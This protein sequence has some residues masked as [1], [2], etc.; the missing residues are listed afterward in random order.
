MIINIKTAVSEN[1][2]IK[3]TMK[4]YILSILLLTG[5]FA[6]IHSQNSNKAVSYQTAPSFGSY[7]NCEGFVLKPGFTYKA[8]TGKA[9]SFKADL[10]VCVA[11]SQDVK[12]S[13]GQNY[14][15][16][17]TPLD[18]TAEAGFSDGKL[19][20]DYGVRANVTV[21]YFDGLGRPVQ[22][23]QRKASADGVSDLVTIQEYDPFGRESNLWL[24]GQTKGNGAYAD[25]STVKSSARTINAEDQNPYSYPVYEASPL[26]RILEQY[27]PGAAWHTGKK[28]IA[29]NY[30][31]NVASNDAKLT[32]SLYSVTG[33]GD[34]TQ[35]KKAGNYAAGELYVTEIKDE[36]QN[37][38][39]EFKDKLGQVI[40]TRQMDGTTAHDTYYVYDDFGNLCYVLPPLATDGLTANSTWAD[41]HASLKQ[42]AYL[43][44]YNDR[45][46]CTKKQLPGCEPIN[47]VYDK[48][49]RLIFSQDGEQRKRITNNQAEWTFNKYD[50]FS[51]LI[52]SGIYRTASTHK[53]MIDVYSAMIFNESTGAGNYGYTWNI[54]SSVPVDDV[55]LINYYDNYDTMLNIN[56]YYKTNLA[57][58]EK[59]GY[60]AKYPNA[61][62]LLVGTRIK[63]INPDG[64]SK[65]TLEGQTVTAMYYD[66]RGNLIQSHSTNHLGG[67]ES[68]YLAY[69]FSGQPKKKQHIHTVT[70]D[71][72]TIQQQ[73]DY[74]YSYDHAGRL[75]KMTHK[76]NNGSEVI[77]AENTYDELG[78]LKTTKANNQA[79]LN[80]TYTYTVRSWTKI[81]NNNNDFI[82]TLD[83]MHNGNIKTQQWK[84]N[85]KERKYTFGYDQLSRLKSATYTSLP[86]P[87]NSKY[88][89]SYT[90]DKHGNV[91][92][93]TRQGL[94][95]PGNYA[96]IDKVT[97]NYT[98][99][100]L[101]KATD[102]IGN[103]SM[104][105]SH[106]FKNYSNA[107]VQYTYN[108]NG[109]MT[110]DLNK[111]I[112]GIKYNSLNLPQE[113]VI[114]HASARA[115][116]YYSYNAAGVK[117][118]TVQK[119]DTELQF[120]PV[121]GTTINN[122]GLKHSITKDYVGNK[123]YENGVL[124]K[125][126][127]DNGYIENGNYYFYVKDH[128][129]NNR[130][131][132]NAAA[133][134]QQTNQYYPFGMMF[135]ESSNKVQDYKYNGKE[136]DLMHGLNHYDYSA[137]QYDPARLQFTTVDP[138]AENYYSW[139]PYA[140]VANN[141]MRYIDPTGMDIIILNSPQ[142][143]HGQGHTAVLIGNEQKGWVY[144]SK[145]G[146]QDK[147]Y[148]NYF[149]GGP[150][151]VGEGFFKSID[152]FNKSDFAKEYEGFTDRARFTSS[153][154]QDHSA[155]KAM[156]SSANSWYHVG[157]NNCVDAV[158][159][160]MEAIGLNPGY[161]VYGAD[162]PYADPISS[163]SDPRP[164]NRF[165]QI[166]RANKDRMIPVEGSK[167]KED[168][169]S[170]Q[171]TFNLASFIEGA[172]AAGAKVTIK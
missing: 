14:I 111:G 13:T 10:S 127:V 6:S 23:V 76:L 93:T 44:K 165:Q 152:D 21:R 164:T 9:M 89:T 134:V 60:G 70:V 136:L 19:T 140:Y 66:Y 108:T 122:D 26:N 161:N 121:L 105:A 98:G 46:L 87:D 34:K 22:T 1:I 124:K 8:A 80:T 133:A 81:I 131:V 149:T 39:Y 128:L 102:A 24:P 86:T 129:G 103:I 107:A 163:V 33:S 145:D 30:K 155:I 142:A 82:E 114:N 172:I 48:A 5:V 18:E 57:Y 109:A 32:C 97:F 115:K 151:K 25:I 42:Y 54:L 100:Q 94:T 153:D 37:P 95:A 12:A 50:S 88:G 55:L 72:K 96:D 120:N 167:Q 159:S 36:E 171:N 7:K 53:A 141:P 125:I 27:G 132:T 52:I 116:N 58:K 69:H 79:G 92:T 15:L 35:L 65:N 56:S 112:Q 113:M 117:L 169:T 77:L 64:T 158:S 11:E 67:I 104:E 59:P 40:L 61:K 130:I 45:K 75:K 49:D 28:A 68:E 157:Y 168:K 154:D 83:Y 118:R 20:L 150:S 101:T 148:S 138:H 29:T 71:N 143:A 162:N 91:K 17:V 85:G 135:A 99:N 160:A 63:T 51:R 119:Y 123:V 110:Q 62:G 139:S 156:R 147:I 106:D 90:Y 47:Y 43:Y 73:E 170:N 137:R 41:S 16:T 126:L 38:S 84:Q 2:Y 146:A 144:I 74:A 3:N 166:K 78:R 4:H 31:T